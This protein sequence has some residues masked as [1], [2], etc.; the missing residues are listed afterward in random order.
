MIPPA[1]DVVR[2]FSPKAEGAVR[3]KVDRGSRLGNPYRIGEHGNRAA[4]VELYREHLEQALAEHEVGT[5]NPIGE[6]FARILEAARNAERLEL[7]CWCAPKP[8]HGDAIHQALLER[9]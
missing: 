2:V 6:A 1:V 8:C 3:F 5:P 7:A 9:P 4:V